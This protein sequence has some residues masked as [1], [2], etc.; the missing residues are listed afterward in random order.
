LILPSILNINYIAVRFLQAEV[1]LSAAS[2]SNNNNNNNDNDN[3]NNN[4]NNNNKR[5]PHHP[6]VNTCGK[7][8]KFM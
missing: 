8:Y 1:L 7:L 3:N 6:H 5:N 4:N 2:K